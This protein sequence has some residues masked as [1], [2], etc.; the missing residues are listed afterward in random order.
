MR[1]I[2]LTAVIINRTMSSTVQRTI[3]RGEPLNALHSTRATLGQSF[4][5]LLTGQT[6]GVAC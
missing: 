1:T 2:Q 5:R 6:V 3:P 4:N